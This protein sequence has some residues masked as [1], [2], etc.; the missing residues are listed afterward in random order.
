MPHWSGLARS[1]VAVGRHSTQNPFSWQE[2]AQ[3][4]RALSKEDA[5][6]CC[7]PVRDYYNEPLWVLREA[8][9]AM[10]EGA[11]VALVGILATSSSYLA[12][13]PGWEPISLPRLGQFDATPLREI[14][15][16][17]G[18]ASPG[19]HGCALARLSL[20]DAREHAGLSRR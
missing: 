7:V 18:G 5:G 2:R 19:N 10:P 15:F 11:S 6:A 1:V 12:R 3:M 17:E 14:F 8:V 4:L 16:G 9:H 20:P 13:F